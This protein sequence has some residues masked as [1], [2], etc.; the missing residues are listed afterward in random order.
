MAKYY[1]VLLL[2]AVAVLFYVFQND[3]CNKNMRADFSRQYPEYKILD[4][5]SR[6]GSPEEVQCHLSYQKPDSDQV[7][8][9]T[10]L[11]RNTESGWLFSSALTKEK[12]VPAP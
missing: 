12:A 8:E 3:P 6:E 2:A 5:G 11:Y 1:F 7:Y 9:D 10:W 4:S